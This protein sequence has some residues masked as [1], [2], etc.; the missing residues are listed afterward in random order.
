[1]AD[2]A[3]RLTDENWKKWKSGCLPFIPERKEKFRRYRHRHSNGSDVMTQIIRHDNGIMVSGYAG[4]AEPGKDIV[5]A[6]VSTLAQ[7]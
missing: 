3:H 4:Y 5:C 2:K 1:M 7:T 6:A